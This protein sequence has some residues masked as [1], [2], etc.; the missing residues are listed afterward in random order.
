MRSGFLLYGAT[1]FV[2]EAIARLAVQRGLKPI[3]AGRNAAK[4]NALAEELSLTSRVFR[5]DDSAALDK[6]LAEVSVV[7]HCAG[8]Y[9]YTYKQMVEGCLRTGTHYLD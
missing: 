5:L 8:P 9:I 6:A 4:V 1:G 2:G 7:L 3:L